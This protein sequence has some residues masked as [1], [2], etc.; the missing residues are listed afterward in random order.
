MNN[1]AAHVEIVVAGCPG[2]GK[3]TLINTLSQN[4]LRPLEVERN[5]PRNG[6]GVNSD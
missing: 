5:S 3:R 6:G 4:A 2:V 1:V